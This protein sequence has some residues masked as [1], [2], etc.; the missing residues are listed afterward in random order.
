[1]IIER[2]PISVKLLVTQNRRQPMAYRYIGCLNG[3]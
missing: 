3:Y 2:Q 1:M